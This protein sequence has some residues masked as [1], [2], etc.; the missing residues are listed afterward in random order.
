MKFQILNVTPDMAAAWL[1]RNQL[2]RPLRKR[3]VA[4]LAD[5]MKR[6]E[7]A[8]NHQPVAINGDKL[9]DGQHRLKAVIESGLPF[10]KMMIAEGAE[11]QTFDTI[12]IGIK[13]SNADIFREDNAIMGP[14]N[15]IARV[16]LMHNVTPREVKP[17]HQKL[18]RLAREVAECA[19]TP[20][21]GMT[22][23]ALKVGIM[24]AI[25][26]GEDKDYVLGM[27]RNMLA[28]KTERLPR[29][30]QLFVR[31]LAMDGTGGAGRLAGAHTPQMMA[32]AYITFKKE[33]ADFER[34]MVKNIGSRMEEIRNVFRKALGIARAQQE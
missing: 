6:G 14:I 12:D 7:W 13:R 28:Y 23:A 3:F 8:V 25:L 26:S 30:G 29:I 21:R 10:V 18:H 1:K 4:A 27:Y 11:S 24:A 5:A 16:C 31:Q 33:N 20:V 19:K 15:M 32:R 2:N 17:F 9:L 34:L 22:S